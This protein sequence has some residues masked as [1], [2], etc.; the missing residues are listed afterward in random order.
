MSSIHLCADIID[1]IMNY[2][3]ELEYAE[4]YDKVLCELKKTIIFEDT[5]I[6]E[7]DISIISFRND[8]RKEYELRYEQVNIGLVGLS[9]NRKYKNITGS[10]YQH[11]LIG[12]GCIEF[13]ETDDEWSR[14]YSDWG[15]DELSTEINRMSGYIYDSDI[16]ISE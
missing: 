10:F 14:S 16:E 8:S 6:F 4:K 2:K 15:S 9:I 1:I 12:V 7:D 5:D 11:E 3:M 13:T